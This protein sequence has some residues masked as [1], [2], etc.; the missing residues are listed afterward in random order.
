[1]ILFSQLSTV[2]DNLVNR[3][4]QE[5]NG[6]ISQPLLLIFIII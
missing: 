3:I 6:K 1:M 5:L 2:V 4:R